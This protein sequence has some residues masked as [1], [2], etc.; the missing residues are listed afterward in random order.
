MKLWSSIKA[1]F[2]D[3][4]KE[5]KDETLEEYIDRTNW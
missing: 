5:D 2:E 4:D 3:F 1:F